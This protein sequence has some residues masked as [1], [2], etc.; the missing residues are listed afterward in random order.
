MLPAYTIDRNQRQANAWRGRSPPGSRT[1][2]TTYSLWHSLILIIPIRVQPAN[3][4]LI[5]SDHSLFNND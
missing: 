4:Q 2:L 3:G 1:H 5:Q